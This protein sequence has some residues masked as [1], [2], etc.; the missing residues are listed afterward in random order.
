MEGPKQWT[1]QTSTVSLLEAQRCAQLQSAVLAQDHQ[2]LM[3]QV[4][5]LAR[6]QCKKAQSDGPKRD[7]G[8]PVAP[9]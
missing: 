8:R 6:R 5:A 1:G 3:M 7:E 9:Q 2:G 4:H